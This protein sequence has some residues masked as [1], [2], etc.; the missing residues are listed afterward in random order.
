MIDIAAYIAHRIVVDTVVDTV[1]LVVV[2]TV[3]RIVACID[4]TM[5]IAPN[6]LVVD[7]PEAHT[8]RGDETREEEEIPQAPDFFRLQTRASAAGILGNKILC[9]LE[10]PLPA[11]PDLTESAQADPQAYPSN[12]Q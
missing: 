6:L 2:G 1:V 12:T 4:P 3:L 11:P 10:G 8:L 5:D 9:F 7:S